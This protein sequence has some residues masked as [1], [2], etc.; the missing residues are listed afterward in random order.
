MP[1]HPVWKKVEVYCILGFASDYDHE[2][3]IRTSAH[4]VHPSG[5]FQ[6]AR[7]PVPFFTID[8][9]GTV[10]ALNMD[11][12]NRDDYDD[13]GYLY[14]DR[15][16]AW[17]VAHSFDEF[18]TRIVRFPNDTNSAKKAQTKEQDEAEIV[19]RLV[20]AGRTADTSRS[21][22]SF[23]TTAGTRSSG[24]L[25]SRA[26]NSRRITAGSEVRRPPRRRNSRLRQPPEGVGRSH[27]PET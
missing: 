18:L 19:D 6:F 27:R 16:P 4:T 5:H 3:L 8:Q 17:P 21:A 14:L 13:D 9:Q 2:S 23:S 1:G 24:T 15:F 25:N 10:Y 11:G 7:S 12:I 26:N 22:A 20:Q